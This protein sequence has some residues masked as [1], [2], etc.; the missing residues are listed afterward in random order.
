[1]ICIYKSTSCNYAP[2]GLYLRLNLY[3]V[4]KPARVFHGVFLFLGFKIKS[5]TNSHGYRV[6]PCGASQQLPVPQASLRLLINSRD[7]PAD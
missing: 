5:L 6:N 7:K 1:M 4:R 2:R 3:A